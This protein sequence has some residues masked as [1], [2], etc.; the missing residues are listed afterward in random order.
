MDAVKAEQRVWA[1][2]AGWLDAI[3]AER[4][5]TRDDAGDRLGDADRAT[6]HE[7]VIGVQARLEAEAS[8]AMLDRMVDPDAPG[9]RTLTAALAAMQARAEKAEAERDAARSLAEAERRYRVEPNALLDRMSYLRARGCDG[10]A[11]DLSDGYVALH[12]RLA[13]ELSAAGGVP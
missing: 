6:M 13:A 5:V 10:E 12:D 1:A 7:A 8:L 4:L 2:L 9:V 3:G 11:D